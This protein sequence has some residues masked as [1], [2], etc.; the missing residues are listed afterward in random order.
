MVQDALSFLLHRF[1]CHLE[2]PKHAS[3]NTGNLPDESPDPPKCCG[4]QDN[5]E[6]QADEAHGQIV[7]A[8]SLEHD[9]CSKPKQ[10][11][12]TR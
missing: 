6:T 12:Q 8:P 2:S 11:Y 3:R 4:T 1:V 10:N 9:D 5:Q 7:P